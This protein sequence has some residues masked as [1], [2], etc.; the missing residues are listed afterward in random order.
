MG[1]D[2][3]RFPE[4]LREAPGTLRAY[5][6]PEPWGTGFGVVSAIKW[7]IEPTLTIDEVVVATPADVTSVREIFAVHTSG[8]ES[9]VVV[10]NRSASRAWALS[11]SSGS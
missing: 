5:S 6:V 11:A 1:Y 3:A 10:E 8:C 2:I 7:E 9:T 4:P